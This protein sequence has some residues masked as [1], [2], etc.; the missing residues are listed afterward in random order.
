MF[1]IYENTIEIEGENYIIKPLSG[2]YIGLLFEV[3]KDLDVEDKE[4]EKAILQKLSADVI[5]K[6][7]EI[8]FQTMKK[9]Y[10]EQQDDKLSDWVSQNLFNLVKPIVKVNIN[11]KQ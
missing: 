9:S 5:A 3:I 8:C 4:D 2:K 1:E 6:L 10:P 7:H 11:N